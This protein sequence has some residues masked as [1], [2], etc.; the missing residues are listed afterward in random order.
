MPITFRRIVEPICR[1][2]SRHP[3]VWLLSI[4]LL[5]VPSALAIRHI[6][7]D[8]DL[9][10]L[11]PTKSP[12]AHWTRTLQKEVGDE[13]FF[14]ILFEGSDP[15]ALL[16]AVRDTAA[17]IRALKGVLSAEYEYPLEFIQRYRYLLVPEYYLERILD[18]LI[19]LEAEVSPLGED[20]L[21]PPAQ[22]SS[23]S[24]KEDAE[25]KELLNRY[26]HLAP[27]HQS[28]GKSVV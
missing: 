18:Y 6:R 5:S 13:G 3:A 2:S 14:T 16:A 23:K 17:R 25:M 21:R 19:G 8:T 10:R 11:L 7:L 22:E 28:R 4:L 24:K 27:Y 26:G 15:D 20:L 12:A 1:S 9:V